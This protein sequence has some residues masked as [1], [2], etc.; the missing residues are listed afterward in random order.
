MALCVTEG[1]DQATLDFV[2]NATSVPDGNADDEGKEG[3]GAGGEGEGEVE[4]TT[5]DG[6]DGKKK[7]DGHGEL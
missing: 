2:T 4:E 3:E 5:K 7:G 1:I 6:K